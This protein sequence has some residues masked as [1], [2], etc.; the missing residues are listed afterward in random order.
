[1]S[2]EMICKEYEAHQED[3]NSVE[4]NPK[5][6][7]ILASCSDDGTLKIWSLVDDE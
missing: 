5:E 2:L 1:M 7:N 3:V 4:W 6:K